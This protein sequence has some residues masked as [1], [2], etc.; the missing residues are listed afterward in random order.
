VTEEAATS[1]VD[2]SRPVVP[3]ITYVG[4]LLGHG[5]DA[6]QMLALADGMQR[7]G[8]TVTIV[9]PAV[10]ESITFAE[11]AESLGVACER[12]SSLRV[13][14]EGSQQRLVDVIGLLR[15]IRSPLVHFHTGNSCLPRSVMIALEL[16]RYRRGFVTLQSPYETIVPGSLRTRFWAATARRRFVAVISPSDHGRRFQV[17]CGVPAER[18]VTVR[19]SIDVARWANGDPCGPRQ[20]L[21]VADDDPL[22][23]FSSRID[24][25][26]RPVDAVRMF[27]AVAAEFP[28]ARLVYVGDGALRQAVVGEADRLG[29][30]G[31]VDLVGYQT[32]VED[33]VAAATVWILPTE[34]ENFSLAV[35][36]AM[37]SGRAVLSTSCPGNDEVLVDGENAAVFA[38]GDI[39]GGAR[40]L[41]ELLVDET[42]R[43]RLG[44]RAAVTAAQFSSEVM[45]DGYRSVYLRSASAPEHLLRGS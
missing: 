31:R 7:R 10:P 26:K 37:A 32:N 1:R 28:R 19:N 13:S 44:D 20:Q 16:L 17:T 6:L 38:V 2:R 9:V 14:A 39:D 45:V 33:W 29:L 12:T 21:G 23:V 3:D 35:L 4:F 40:R 15:S 43:T 22:V 27:A 42:L 25:Q 30:G 5:G 18:A 34:R 36:E 41:R 24:G 11:R 8:A